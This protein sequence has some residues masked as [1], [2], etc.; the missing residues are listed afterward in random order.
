VTRVDPDKCRALAMFFLGLAARPG[1]EHQTIRD[2]WREAA[3][4]LE[5]A[6]AAAELGDE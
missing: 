2:A 3:D 5:A 1:P 4:Q 6:A